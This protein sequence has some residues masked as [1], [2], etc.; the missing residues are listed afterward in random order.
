MIVAARSHGHAKA[1]CYQNGKDA[2]YSIPYTDFRSERE[3]VFDELA[4]THAGK[5]GPISLGWQDKHVRFG[6]LEKQE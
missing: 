2:G 5:R 3:K 1:G 6:C 4:I